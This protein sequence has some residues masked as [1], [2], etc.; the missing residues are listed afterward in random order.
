MQVGV[1]KVGHRERILQALKARHQNQMQQQ[2]PQYDNGDTV[3]L[4]LADTS[5]SAYAYSEYAEPLTSVSAA[6][7]PTNAHASS[8]YSHGHNNSFLS[9]VSHGSA[10]ATAPNNGG[11]PHSR[12]RHQGNTHPSTRATDNRQSAAASSIDDPDSDSP[13]R[14]PPPAAPLGRSRHDR[15]ITLPYEHSTSSSAAAGL[16]AY[17]HRPPQHP[18]QNDISRRLQGSTNV[19]SST[20]GQHR[21]GVLSQSDT[22][23]DDSSGSVQPRSQPEGQTTR[24]HSSTRST[25]DPKVGPIE[26]RNA[27]KDN[28]ENSRH[29]SNVGWQQGNGMQTDK[30]PQAAADEEEEEYVVS[31]NA[32]RN[33]VQASLA[34]QHKRGVLNAAKLAYMVTQEAILREAEGAE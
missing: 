3:S 21:S 15:S 20:H 24:I 19:G 10:N 16:A 6:S 28:N 18:G 17:Y 7:S 29:G 5:R 26:F 27:E 11:M 34:T 14:M 8:R 4:T 9:R 12:H 22:G 30:G 33:R 13:T 23:V 2:M 1:K 31:K 25:S 32:R